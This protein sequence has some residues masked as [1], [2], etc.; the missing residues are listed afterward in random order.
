MLYNVL[1][2]EVA[3]L[4]FKDILWVVAPVILFLL[5][6]IPLFIYLPPQGVTPLIKACVFPIICAV[7]V[8]T[9]SLLIFAFLPKVNINVLYAICFILS[10]LCFC[11]AF[12]HQG[13]MPWA[14]EEML[15]L[16][17]ALNASDFMVPFFSFIFVWLTVTAFLIRTVLVF[18]RGRKN[19]KNC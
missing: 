3:F 12:I 11:V 13:H 5:L 7:A 18:L 10:A 1:R 4:K 15:V 8:Q 6:S 19:E 2:K 17:Y 14:T 9:V 16:P